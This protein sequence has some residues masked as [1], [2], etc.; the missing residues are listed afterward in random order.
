MRRKVPLSVGNFEA[1][2]AKFDVNPTSLGL[3]HNDT[4]CALVLAFS[5]VA[6]NVE[7]FLLTF[8]RQRPLAAPCMASAVRFHIIIMIRRSQHG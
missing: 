7:S 6:R 1:G 2:A 3:V 8:S 4:L 5:R